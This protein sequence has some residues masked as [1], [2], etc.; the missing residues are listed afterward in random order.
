MIYDEAR[1][2]CLRQ[3]AILATSRVLSR[4]DQFSVNRPRTLTPDRRPKMPPLFCTNDQRL[5]VPAL[6]GVAEGRQA[7]VMRESGVSGL[8]AVL[9]APAVVASFD[10]I[11][12]MSQS[13]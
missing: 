12:V 7:R 3:Q 8:S 13:I 4:S 5:P 9:E 10:D 1:R 6:V 11:A 2:L